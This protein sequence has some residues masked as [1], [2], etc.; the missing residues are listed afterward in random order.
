MS[1]E[2]KPLAIDVR[3]TPQENGMYVAYVDSDLP[4]LRFAARKLLMYVNGKWSYPG[5]SINFRGE[6]YGWIGPLPALRYYNPKE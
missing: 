4:H 2:V 1:S 3:N 6:I 5:S